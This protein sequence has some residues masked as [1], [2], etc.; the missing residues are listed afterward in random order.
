M[1]T[2]GTKLASTSHST[3]IQPESG[4]PNKLSCGTV[5]GG[6]GGAL[7]AQIA[8]HRRAVAPRGRMDV[9]LVPYT[10]YTGQLYGHGLARPLVC[11]RPPPSWWMRLQLLL[12]RHTSCSKI[13]ADTS[14]LHVMQQFWGGWRLARRR[15]I[16]DCKLWTIYPAMAELGIWDDTG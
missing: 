8:R 2:F 16:S 11:V 15:Q 13:N 5:T 12:L 4:G 6:P 3:I 1:R 7:C 10:P 14:L 9:A